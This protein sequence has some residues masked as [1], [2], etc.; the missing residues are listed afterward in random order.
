MC[1]RDRPQGARAVRF[2]YL[3]G[4]FTA[5]MFAT[6]VALAALSGLAVAVPAGRRRP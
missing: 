4:S 1:I 2:V 3:P 5:G 6:L